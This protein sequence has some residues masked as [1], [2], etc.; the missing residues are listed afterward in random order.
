[1]TICYSFP[2]R[3][4][5]HKFFAALNNIQDMSESKDYFVVAKLD[6]DDVTMNN[7]EVKEKIAKEYPEVIVKWG[8]SKSKIDAINRGMEDLPE[9]DVLCLHSD[10]M[11]FIEW[12]FDAEIRDA[13]KD[14][15]GLVHFPDGH[16]NEKLITY[17]MM[18]VDYYKQLGYIYHPSFMN[19]YCDNF[20]QEQAKRLNKYKFVNK[21]IL[22]HRHPIWGYG[23]ADDL[24]K[25]TENPEGYR[26]DHETFLRLKQ[27]NGWA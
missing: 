10:D 23:V 6:L 24:L 25:R 20:Q 17:S 14:W 21:N 12:G 1:M 8:Y 4:R 3:E 27:E 19:V 2:S 13:F 7:D 22:E 18:H 26:Q 9:F 11:K 15:D 16:V 5:P